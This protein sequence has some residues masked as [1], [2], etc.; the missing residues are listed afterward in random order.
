M[1]SQNAKSVPHGTAGG[2]AIN[3]DLSRIDHARTRKVTLG[4]NYAITRE[5]GT[6]VRPQFTGAEPGKLDFPRTLN[7]GTTVTLSAEEAAA[8]VA[9]GKATY[10]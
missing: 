4:A 10:A 7:S 2:T 6:P 1:P 3:A 8:L 5:A 9:A